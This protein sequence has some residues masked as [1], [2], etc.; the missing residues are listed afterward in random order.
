[1]TNQHSIKNNLPGQWAIV[2]TYQADTDDDNEFNHDMLERAV[3][4]AAFSVGP[5]EMIEGSWASADEFA[6][7]I[8]GSK[9][10]DFALHLAV[11]YAQMAF[12]VAPGD[13][14]ARLMSRNADGT[15]SES[16]RFE[17]IQVLDSNNLDGETD[18]SILPGGLAFRLVP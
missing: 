18:Y 9:A 4:R 11:Q 3:A 12:I 14:S 15:F 10:A 16:A 13:G 1:M 8:H 6:I 2:T 5:V 17:H 7:R